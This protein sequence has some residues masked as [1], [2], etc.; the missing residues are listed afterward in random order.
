MFDPQVLASLYS[1]E[2]EVN[3][4]L[5]A[6]VPP[7]LQRAESADMLGSELMEGK[8]EGRAEEEEAA[9]DLN[10]LSL[11][12]GA[13]QKSTTQERRFIHDSRNENPHE[14]RQH[15]QVQ[16]GGRYG[17]NQRVLPLPR[18]AREEPPSASN[19]DG[20]SSNNSSGG[21]GTDL[22]KLYECAMPFA[23]GTCVAVT[24]TPGDLFALT[25]EDR[26]LRCQASAQVAAGSAVGQ[27][28][29]FVS[30]REFKTPGADVLRWQLC[31]LMLQPQTQPPQ[32]F[33]AA[34]LP[35]VSAGVSATFAVGLG[36]KASI[37]S[38]L[39]LLS[40]NFPASAEVLPMLA[41]RDGQVVDR[42]MLDTGAAWNS[43][44]T[45]AAFALDAQPLYSIGLLAL[46]S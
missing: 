33:D 29:L 46:L 16:Q 1:S 24:T 4:V 25:A 18:H 45:T 5:L 34:E 2:R 36:F 32:H 38:R 15:R 35:P 3:T 6:S 42:N 30:N 8:G 20:H 40:D 9:H 43:A 12:S 37:F 11:T 7:S 28:V 23:N 39:A 31:F 41:V 10:N 44:A 14:Q 21:N 22:L 26:G 13:V 27:Y 17:E 19:S